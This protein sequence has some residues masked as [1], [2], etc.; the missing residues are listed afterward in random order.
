MFGSK[1]KSFCRTTGAWYNFFGI[2]TKQDCTDTKKSEEIEI[3]EFISIN[4]EKHGKSERKFRTA[5]QFDTLERIQVIG[6]LTV[7][8]I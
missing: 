7:L 8:Q 3:I 2:V 4:C 6:V 5:F 1:S